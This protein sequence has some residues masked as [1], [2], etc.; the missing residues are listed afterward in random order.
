MVRYGWSWMFGR[1]VI[2]FCRFRVKAA[3]DRS[4]PAMR[5]GVV[6]HSAPALR[7]GSHR[8]WSDLCLKYRSFWPRQRSQVNLRED[9]G[10]VFVFI[11]SMTALWKP[12][13]ASLVSQESHGLRDE[14]ARGVAGS[15]KLN[16]AGIDQ[17]GPACRATPCRGT[18]QP[19]TYTGYQASMYIG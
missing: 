3:D 1:R 15:W 16:T 14:A 10:A 2:S 12:K 18:L 11:I 6:R 19:T 4:S 17:R 7:H 13:P 8:S 9:N 5:V